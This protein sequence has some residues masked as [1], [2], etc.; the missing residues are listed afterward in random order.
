MNLTASRRKGNVTRRRV[1]TTASAALL[2]PATIATAE[3]GDPSGPSDPLD[4]HARAAVGLY[5]S[6]GRRV[7]EASRQ[8]DASTLAERPRYELAL[9]LAQIAE[10]NAEQDLIAAILALHGSIDDV[11]LWGNYGMFDGTEPGTRGQAFEHA[12]Y[13]YELVGAIPR[14]RVTRLRSVAVSA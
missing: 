10:K 12:G 5:R 14:V 1:P 3:G 9:S 13:R 6:A 4:R 2:A 11:D 8:H 7:R